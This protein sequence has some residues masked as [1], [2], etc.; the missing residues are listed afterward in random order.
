MFNLKKN[1]DSAEISRKKAEINVGIGEYHVGELAM[2]AIGLGSCIALILHDPERCV[3]GMAHIML[4]SSNGNRDRPGK[5]ADTAVPV[6]IRE[7]ESMDCTR[8][9]LVAKMAGGSCMFQ[10]FMGNLN[11]GERNITA[12]RNTLENHGIPVQAED[13]GGT[14][15]R[16]IIYYPR[17]NGRVILKQAGGEWIDI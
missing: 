14:G 3:G 7:L 9:A 13:I 15:G 11:I 1:R 6:L 4:P 12:I 5:F 10:N 8:C 16:S 17:N 2:S